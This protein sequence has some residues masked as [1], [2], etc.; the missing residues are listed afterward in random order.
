VNKGQLSKASKNKLLYPLNK[1]I[2]DP[3]DHQKALDSMTPQQRKEYA[4]YL[5]LLNSI[6]IVDPDSL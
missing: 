5:A 2:Y 3:V 4:S 6:G 1:E